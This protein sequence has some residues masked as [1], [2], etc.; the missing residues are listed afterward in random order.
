MDPKKAKKSSKPR[1]FTSTDLQALIRAKERVVCARFSADVSR[2]N[3]LNMV[4]ELRQVKVRAAVAEDARKRAERAL[5]KLARKCAGYRDSAAAK[6][7]V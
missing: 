7:Y 6:P 3:V 1:Y 5:T 2:Q 4:K